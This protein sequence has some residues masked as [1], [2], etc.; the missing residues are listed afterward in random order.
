MILV[1]AFS[2]TEF[3]AG[4]GVSQSFELR[5]AEPGK[6]WVLAGTGYGVQPVLFMDMRIF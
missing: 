2:G 4:A 1:A 3:V 6:L 5:L